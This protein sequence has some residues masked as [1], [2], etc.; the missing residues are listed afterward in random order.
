MMILDARNIARGVEVKIIEL[1]REHKL[2]VTS[3]PGEHNLLFYKNLIEDIQPK[4]VVIVGY[5]YL[6]EFQALRGYLELCNINL[7]LEN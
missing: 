3:R 4:D 5:Q 6:Q 2:I 7:H 1:G